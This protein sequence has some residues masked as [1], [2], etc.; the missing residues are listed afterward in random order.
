MTFFYYYYSLTH[1]VF[2]FDRIK[3]LVNGKNIGHTHTHTHASWTELIDFFSH[4]L[5]LHHCIILSTSSRRWWWRR[6]FFRFV[7]PFKHSMIILFFSIPL[8]IQQCY[9]I[10]I[11]LNNFTQQWWWWWWSNFFLCSLV[12]KLSNCQLM[13]E[14][15]MYESG[16]TKHNR[17]LDF[18]FWRWNQMK[19]KIEIEKP[20]ENLMMISK[21]LKKGNIS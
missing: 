8:I 6:I 11:F 21:L 16:K 2:S 18:F 1:C 3:N 9:Q 15:F 10:F 20:E 19:M 14:T 13:H 12:W 17:W 4:S 5:A 7:V